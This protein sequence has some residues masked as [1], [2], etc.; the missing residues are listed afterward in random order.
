[1][2]GHNFKE[3]KKYNEPDD[4]DEINLFIII[5]CSPESL[6]ICS[7]LNTVK[8]ECNNTINI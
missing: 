2:S 7:L 6:Q 5:K 1:M 3:V 8:M 4:V